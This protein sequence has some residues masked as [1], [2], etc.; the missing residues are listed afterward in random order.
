MIYFSCSDIKP[1]NILF[2]DNMTN[3]RFY[4]IDLGSSDFYC[5]GIAEKGECLNPYQQNNNKNH[6]L[7]HQRYHIEYQDGL[8]LIGT[9]RYASFNA[10]FGI[11]LSRRDDLESLGYTLIYLYRD[12]PWQGISKHVTDTKKML[13][14]TKL[15]KIQASLQDLCFGLPG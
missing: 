1:N 7:N 13:S 14:I 10:L 4:L 2:R 9:P 11:Q 12:L 15:A 5:S 8:E 6:S 3:N